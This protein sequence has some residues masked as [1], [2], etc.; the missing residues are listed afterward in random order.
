MWL[1]QGR[2]KGSRGLPAKFPVE[3]CVEKQ[4]LKYCQAEAWK[5]CAVLCC[6]VLWFLA[7]TQLLLWYRFEHWA[8]FFHNSFCQNA[9]ATWRALRTS[10]REGPGEVPLL[11]PRSCCFCTQDAPGVN[12][13]HHP[14][15]SCRT[16]QGSRFPG[17]G[18]VTGCPLVF[19]SQCRNTAKK[20]IKS[21]KRQINRQTK[22]NTKRENHSQ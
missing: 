15:E 19:L 14:A 1:L 11:H 13:Q 5:C 20:H 3:A 9:D 2:E 18:V 12:L 8:V 4:T 21:T 17:R 7:R 22:A 16:G 10:H 6:A